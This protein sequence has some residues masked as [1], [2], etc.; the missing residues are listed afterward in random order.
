[1][2]DVA[3]PDF[4]RR[5]WRLPTVQHRLGRKST[6]DV[7][8]V[9]STA[10]R[11]A[12]EGG[13]EAATLPKVAAELDVSAMSL[14]RH[15][16]SKYELLQLMMD[17]ASEPGATPLDESSGWRD[18]LRQWASNLWSLYRARPWIPRVP[19]YR[20]PSGPHQIAW[21]ER[22]FEQLALTEF[23]WNEKLTALTLLSG[24]VRQS[25]LLQQELEEGREAGQAQSDSEQEYGAAL[26]HLVDAK[27]F[28]QTAAMLTSE[29][30][31]SETTGHDESE[32]DFLDGLEII[33]DG[34]AARVGKGSPQ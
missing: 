20:A 9:V 34:L 30:F 13:L 11:L 7:E 31:A 6:L 28:P 27:Q 21:L 29:V 18:G 24:F 17:A 32:R 26:Q 8:T 33:L 4:F 25:A 12:D 22:G 15:I 16:G 10:V 2:N 3:V 23:D 1:M 14:Y 5:L 19:I